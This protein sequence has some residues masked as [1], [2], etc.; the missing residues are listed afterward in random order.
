LLI[1]WM[2]VEGRNFGL[3]LGLCGPMPQVGY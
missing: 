3:V 2:C 1:L